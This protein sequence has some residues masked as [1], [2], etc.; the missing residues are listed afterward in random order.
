V[1]ANSPEKEK[2]FYRLAGVLYANVFIPELRML[3][4]KIPHHG[5]AV[6]ILKHLNDYAPG[7]QQVFFA[8]KRAV[9]AHNDSWYPVEKNGAAAHG[10]GR[11]RGVKHAFTVNRRRLASGIFQGVHVTMQDGT[12]FLHATSVSS[13]K[14]SS[15]V[16]H[17][18]SNGNT[19]FTQT[20]PCF[21]DG[22]FDELI[23]AGGLVRGHGRHT[24]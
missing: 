14:D 21:F 6:L 4:D 8:H 3:L 12:A 7:A 16:N 18:G 13:A 19:A 15:L 10:T 22:C 5:D 11:K 1:A 2:L 24:V 20:Q 17:Y 9:L 23:V